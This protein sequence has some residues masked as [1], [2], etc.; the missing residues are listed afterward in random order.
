[1]VI[2]EVDAFSNASQIHPVDAFFKRVLIIFLVTLLKRA[3]TEKYF[4]VLL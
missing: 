4:Q 3:S 1:M 2:S